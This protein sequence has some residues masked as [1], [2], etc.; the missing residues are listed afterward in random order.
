MYTEVVPVLLVLRATFEPVL[1]FIVCISG[2]QEKDRELLRYKALVDSVTN[3]VDDIT[4]DSKTANQR[5]SVFVNGRDIERACGHLHS[6]SSPNPRSPRLV[7]GVAYGRFGPS[8]LLSRASRNSIGRH[9]WCAG[10]RLPTCILVFLLER[11]LPA[12]AVPGCGSLCMHMHGGGISFKRRLYVPVTRRHAH[13]AVILLC[14]SFAACA[15]K[16]YSNLPNY[17]VIYCCIFVRDQT[18]HPDY[19]N[20]LCAHEMLC[21]E[22]GGIS[23][24]CDRLVDPC[25]ILLACSLR[26]DG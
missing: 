10:D 20:T 6:S 5:V 11:K 14:M 26:C 1:L 23:F 22:T 8:P 4:G 25:M 15:V 3:T 12:P 17:M 2:E 16:F 7:G 13:T 18:S 19:R 24:W 21:G 9:C